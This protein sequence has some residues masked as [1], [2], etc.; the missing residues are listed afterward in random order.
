MTH[1]IERQHKFA[2]HNTEILDQHRRESALAVLEMCH[3]QVTAGTVNKRT[4]VEKLSSAYAGILHTM[5]RRSGPKQ[6][7]CTTNTVASGSSS[8]ITNTATEAQSSQNG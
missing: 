6:K 1:S 3:I 8:G 2:Y 7:T 4:D 5:M